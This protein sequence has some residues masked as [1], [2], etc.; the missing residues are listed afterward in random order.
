MQLYCI[1][2]YLCVYVHKCVVCMNIIKLFWADHINVCMYVC[3]F[4]YV[5]DILY[6][7]IHKYDILFLIP[8]DQIKIAW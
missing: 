5:Y 1:V 3:Y 8:K 6:W 7:I 2:S 4:M